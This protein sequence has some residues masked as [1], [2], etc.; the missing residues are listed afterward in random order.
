[1]GISMQIS[2][3]LVNFQ[4]KEKDRNLIKEKFTVFNCGML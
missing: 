2:R 3:N 4:L 1:M